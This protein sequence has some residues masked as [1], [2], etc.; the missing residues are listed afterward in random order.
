[1]A[2]QRN[3]FTF[4]PSYVLQERFSGT[5]KL[6][7]APSDGSVSATKVN[8]LLGCAVFHLFI[9]SQFLMFHRLTSSGLNLP[10][11]RSVCTPIYMKFVQLFAPRVDTIGGGIKEHAKVVIFGVKDI[12]DVP[13]PVIAAPLQEGIQRN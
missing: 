12:K 5:S 2:E 1:V 10:R 7:L 3:I 13:E 6:R 8:N 9:G 4:I 11:V